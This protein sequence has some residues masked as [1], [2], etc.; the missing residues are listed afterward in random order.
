MDNDQYGHMNN[1]V[2]YSLFDTAVSNWQM[3]Q[4]GFNVTGEVTK[5]MVVESGCRYFDE[6]GYPDLIHVGLRLGH[7]GNS[8]WR[9]DLG[10]FRNEIGTA[11]A[12][13]FFAQVQVDAKSGLPTPVSPDMRAALEQLR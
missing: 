13:G 6:A 11:F 5:L 1:V 4:G 9:Y 2:H 8:S 12:E 3:A 7:L 10:L